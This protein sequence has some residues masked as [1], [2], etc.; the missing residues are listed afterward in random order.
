MWNRIKLEL[1]VIFRIND[2]MGSFHKS[3]RNHLP[4]IPAVNSISYC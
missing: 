3:I 1:R 4:I 2:Y